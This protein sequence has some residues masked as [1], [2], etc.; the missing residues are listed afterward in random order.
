MCIAVLQVSVRYADCTSPTMHRKTRLLGSRTLVRTGTN[1]ENILPQRQVG[2]L[3]LQLC[4]ILY[5]NT[6]SIP[7]G[8]CKHVHEI[9]HLGVPCIDLSVSAPYDLANWLL[10]MPMDGSFSPSLHELTKS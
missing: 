4:S 3:N 10:V 1:L 5:N 2:D 9:A 7:K 6:L 8:L